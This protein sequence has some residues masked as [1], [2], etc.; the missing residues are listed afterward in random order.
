MQVAAKLAHYRWKP[1]LITAILVLAP[2]L[3]LAAQPATAP[4][5]SYR[6]FIDPL[7]IYRYWYW[8]LLP[9][10]VLFSVVYKAVKCESMKEVPRQAIS[11]TF[12]I[13]LGM[14]SAAVGLALVV[15]ILQ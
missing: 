15:K 9:L 7:P 8:L 6:M 10:C 11:I 12:W 3:F 14:A 13:L 2:T 1:S 4:T 5:Q